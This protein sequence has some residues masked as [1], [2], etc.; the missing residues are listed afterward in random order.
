MYCRLNCF[1]TLDINASLLFRPYSIFLGAPLRNTE[2]KCLR[3]VGTTAAAASCKKIWAAG[4]AIEKKLILSVLLF[5]PP[6]MVT[7]FIHH[8]KGEEMVFFKIDI[9]VT[10]STN[11]CL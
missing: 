2:C 10:S 5:D 3:E 9:I 6:A 8:M 11:K 4:M 7:L 1:I